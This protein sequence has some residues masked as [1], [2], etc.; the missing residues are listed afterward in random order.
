MNKAIV[1]AAAS[2]VSRSVAPAD[3]LKSSTMR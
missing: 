2:D 1:A 3:S